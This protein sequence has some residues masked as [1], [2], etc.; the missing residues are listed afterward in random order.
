MA[1]LLV[2]IG[3]TALKAAWSEG[4][5]LGRTFRY[6]GENRMEFI[7]SLTARE[8]PVILA[9]STSCAITADEQTMLESECSHLVILDPVH[10]DILESR[11]IPAYLSCDRAASVIA[12]RHCF[13]GRPCTVFDFGTTLSVDFISADGSYQGGNISLGCMTRLKALNRY[14]RSLPLIQLP[15]ENIPVGQ[16]VEES[17]EAGTISGIMFEIEGYRRR[18]PQ[19]LVV[20][21]GGDAA[22]FARL[23]EASVFVMANM[24]LTGLSIIT[25]EYV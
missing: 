3:N 18:Y 4:T 6:Q 19:N 9:V 21:T 2:E 22:Y 12:A 23:S 10:R 16:S 17:I 20:F 25:D 5:T 7:L 14:S 1:N 24:A 8:K 15:T 13:K 11:G